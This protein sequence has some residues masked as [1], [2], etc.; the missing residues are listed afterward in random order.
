MVAGRTVGAVGAVMSVL[1][2]QEARALALGVGAV[3]RHVACRA[4]VE[5]ALGRLL[6][7]CVK[8]PAH[9]EPCQESQALCR[10]ASTLGRG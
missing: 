6:I 7:V 10:S 1:R 8:V 2:T 9:V 5:A 4:A 3:T